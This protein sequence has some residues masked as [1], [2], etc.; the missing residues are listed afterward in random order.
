M[1]G[2]PEEAAYLVKASRH[3]QEGTAFLIFMIRS[4]SSSLTVA[5]F[6]TQCGIQRLEVNHW[7]IAWT[8]N[9]GHRFCFMLMDSDPAMANEDGVQT[10][11]GQ[12]CLHQAIQRYT[13]SIARSQLMIRVKH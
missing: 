1:G 2:A 13:D 12:R 6:C 11:C 7:F 3:Q 4:A 9:S 10:L 5:V 8:E